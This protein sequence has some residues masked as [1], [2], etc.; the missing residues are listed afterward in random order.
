MAETQWKLCR[1]W[2]SRSGHTAKVNNHNDRWKVACRLASNAIV[3]RCKDHIQDQSSLLAY[4]AMFLY[5]P[6]VIFITFCW[7][8]AGTC[9]P[10]VFVVV[11][12]KSGLCRSNFAWSEWSEILFHDSSETFERKMST[13]IMR[14]MNTRHI[15]IGTH[16]IYRFRM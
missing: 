14:A 11:L 2:K 7:W 9:R 10:F 6:F 16:I 5:A 8:W 1:R 15:N 12:V 4:R 3:N 13:L